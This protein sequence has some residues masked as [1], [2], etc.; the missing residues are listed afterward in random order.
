MAGS[1]LAKQ[2]N[3]YAN[4]LRFLRGKIARLQ[5]KPNPPQALVTPGVQNYESAYMTV[6]D[7]RILASYK[8]ISSGGIPVPSPGCCIKV[9]VETCSGVSTFYPVSPGD[10]V[11]IQNT[12]SDPSIV[13]YVWYDQ[14][15][16]AIGINTTIPAASTTTTPPAPATAAFIGISC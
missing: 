5:Y 11:I 8:S 13:D 1:L 10:S 4:R 14:D 9:T 16:N 2:D 7:G 3:S 12:L 6:R 15:N